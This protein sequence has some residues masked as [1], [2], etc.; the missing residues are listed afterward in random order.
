MVWKPLR[1]GFTVQGTHSLNLRCCHSSWNPL[2][3]CKHKGSWKASQPQHS[4]TAKWSS[5]MYFFFVVSGIRTK[6]ALCGVLLSLAPNW[7]SKFSSRRNALSL[8]DVSDHSFYSFLFFSPAWCRK[9][10]LGFTN[11]SFFKGV[12]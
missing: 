4:L 7:P 3:P 12:C 11:S 1:R 9:E 10:W 8:L 6:P 5:E 2:H